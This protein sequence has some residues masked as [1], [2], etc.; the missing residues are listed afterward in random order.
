[1]T[2]NK[3]PETVEER[4]DLIVDMITMAETD[5]REFAYLSPAHPEDKTQFRTQ[6]SAIKKK[7]KVKRLGASFSAVELHVD[8]C[9]AFKAGRWQ[10]SVNL[11]FQLKNLTR[12]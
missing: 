9:E 3:K 6:N 12:R 5:V 2:K 4:A 7:V 11:Y 8:F 1:M 10:E